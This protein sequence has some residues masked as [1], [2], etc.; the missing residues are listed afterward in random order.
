MSRP[1]PAISVENFVESTLYTI[2][3]VAAANELQQL[4][5]FLRWRRVQTVQ[6]LAANPGVGEVLQ[7]DEEGSTIWDQLLSDAADD[8]PYVDSLNNLN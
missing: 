7:R 5:A 1:P 8:V 3:S 2:Q 4:A 6:A